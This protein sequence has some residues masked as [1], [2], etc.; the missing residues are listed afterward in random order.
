MSKDRWEIDINQLTLDDL[1]LLE[2][3]DQGMA[4]K[5]GAIKELLGRLLVNR[6]ADEV[7][8]LT[9]PELAD[10]VTHIGK[11]VEESALPKAT[12]TD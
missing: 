5:S 6:S 11:A 3:A 1:I 8:K 4:G 2:E 9:L 10:L 12:N 7:G